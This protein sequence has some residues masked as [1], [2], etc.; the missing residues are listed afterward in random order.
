MLN[1]KNTIENRNNVIQTLLAG[2]QDMMD[3]SD[4]HSFYK[5]VDFID[6]KAFLGLLYLRACLKLNMFH[7]ETIWR[8]ESAN[9]FF[10]QLL[11]FYFEIHNF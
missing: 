7:R 4:K 10:A 11:C 5:K 9:D 3:D 6:I 2:K 8:H 1:A